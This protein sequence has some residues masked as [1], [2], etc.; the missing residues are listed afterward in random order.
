MSETVPPLPGC[1]RCDAK[2]EAEAEKMCKPGCDE[3]PMAE[4]R[5]WDVQLQYLADLIAYDEQF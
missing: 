2:T 3:C 5:P 4:E 1:P